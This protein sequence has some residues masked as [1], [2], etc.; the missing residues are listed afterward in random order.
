MAKRNS[1]HDDAFSSVVDKSNKTQRVSIKMISN[2]KLVAYPNNEEDTSMLAELENSIKEIGFTDPLEVIPHEDD[3]FMILSGHRRRL[4]GVNAGI[5]SFPCIVKEFKNQLEIENYVLL[6]NLH[7]DSSKDPLLFCKRYKM[8]EAY[9]DNSN[10]KGS[11]REEIAKRL[12]ISPTQA[13]RYNRFN[14]IILPIWDL[15]REDKV[16]MSSV[17]NMY[18]LPVEEQS[19]IYEIFLTYLND[20]ERLTREKCE[21]IIRD[22]VAA[23]DEEETPDEETLDEEKTIETPRRMLKPQAY[24]GLRISRSLNRLN[25]S[26]GNDYEFDSPEL[27]QKTMKTMMLTAVSIFDELEKLKDR[28]ENEEIRNELIK[29][30]KRRLQD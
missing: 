28:Y 10:F 9:L 12:G 1:L 17:I 18:T 19:Q 2:N 6:A 16:G 24:E 25:C 7:R 8:H 14:K 13:D 5:S 21:S 11:K 29:E 15:V 26:F 27:A 3:K 20:E 30:Y 23:K 22:F 4:A